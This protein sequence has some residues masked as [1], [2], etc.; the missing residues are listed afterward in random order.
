MKAL[1]YCIIGI[2]L[3]IVVS[4][5]FAFCFTKKQND[6]YN[7][8]FFLKIGLIIVSPFLVYAF[9]TLVLML[10][11]C[12]S[13]VGYYV[14][15]DTIYY[16]GVDYKEVT[17]E[18]KIEEINDYGDGYWTYTETFISSDEITFPYF[19]YWIPDLFYEQVVVP[20][21]KDA[22]YIILKSLDEQSYF[23]RK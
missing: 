19:E 16:D 10:F 6:F 14:A 17:D 8:K 13:F 4:Y 20:G 1:I 9:I 3:I 2:V 22:M 7:I 11:R 12:N 23:E 15:S 5:I 18:A 21:D